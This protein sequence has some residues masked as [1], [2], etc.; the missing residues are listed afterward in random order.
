MGGEDGWGGGGSEKCLKSVTYYFNSHYVSMC[1]KEFPCG[2]AANTHVGEID[3]WLEHADTCWPFKM[4]TFA[5]IR[6]STLLKRS[7]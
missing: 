4:S 7:K 1:E 6:W 2:R 5:D 3:T